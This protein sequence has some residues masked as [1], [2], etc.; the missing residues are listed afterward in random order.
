M[1]RWFGS[2]Y[3]LSISPQKFR[4]GASI[5]RELLNDFL[6][7]ISALVIF[8][9]QKDLWNMSCFGS[10]VLETSQI[11]WSDV[12]VVITWR[13]KVWTQLIF[14]FWTPKKSP[15]KKQKED[16]HTLPGCEPL[17]PS[18]D[19]SHH[20]PR[21]QSSHITRMTWW[22]F[23]RAFWRQ[24]LGSEK[25]HRKPLVTCKRSW[26]NPASWNKA[27]HGSVP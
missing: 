9:S 16:D 4:V 20:Y 3:F 19:S 18:Q 24:C 5:W 25:K 22:C 10:R 21:M 12:A 2:L 23:T 1:A 15:S 7:K 8:P 6:K 27:I 14:K 13:V 17:N 11:G 26:A